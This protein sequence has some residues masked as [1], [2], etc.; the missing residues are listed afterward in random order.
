MISQIDSGNF[1]IVQAGGRQLILQPGC[2]Y[3][4]NRLQGEPKDIVKLQRVLL[5]KQGNEVLIGQ[6][7]IKNQMVL[8]ILLQHFRGKKI[9]VFKYIPKKKY[10]RKKGYRSSLTRVFIKQT[11]IK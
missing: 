5:Q 11:F 9:C 8:G 1:S 2:W 6:P 4:M 7:C 3:D 10:T